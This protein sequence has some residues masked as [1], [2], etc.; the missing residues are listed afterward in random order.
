MEPD[1]GA[2]VEPGMKRDAA[3]LRHETQ[4]D[5]LHLDG[6]A[7]GGALNQLFGRDA[8]ADAAQCGACGA[9]NPVGA[10]IVYNCAPGHVIRCPACSSV[11][12][13]LVRQ[14]GSYRL[15]LEALHAVVLADV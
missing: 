7:L 10:L 3:R 1:T 4:Q 5:H 2:D 15:T 8:T 14:R 9:A 11:L 13:V 6:N 12:F